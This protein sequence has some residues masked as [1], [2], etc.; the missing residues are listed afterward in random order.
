MPKTGWLRWPVCSRAAVPSACSRGEAQKGRR[1]NNQPARQAPVETAGGCAQVL[2]PRG[3]G[4]PAGATSRPRAEAPGSAGRAPGQ[5]A[6]RG[7]RPAAGQRW[8]ASRPGGRCR[9]GAAP[10][11]L[12]VPQRRPSPGGRNPRSGADSRRPTAPRAPGP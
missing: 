3:T 8:A 2:R 4:P 9:P 12:G 1:A 10:A 5:R 6:G 7:Q 11:A